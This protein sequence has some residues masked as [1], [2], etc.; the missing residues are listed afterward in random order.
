M[1]VDYTSTTKTIDTI[2]TD[3][4]KFYYGEKNISSPYKI[5][6]PLIKVQP[7]QSI[8]FSA[9]STIGCEK[10]S[11]IYSAV[12]VCFFKEINPNEYN[13]II[14]S[15]GQLSENRIIE[16]GLINIIE[17]IENISKTIP[18]EQKSNQGEII[19]HGENHTIGNLISHGMQKHKNVKFAGYNIPHLLEEKVIITYELVNDKIML[20]DIIDDVIIYYIKIF[21]ELINLNSDLKKSTKKNPKKNSK[22]NSKKL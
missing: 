17:T 1:Y 14:E 5:A 9:I 8:N 12:S 7:G 21:K 6:I 10:E 13:L 19:I 4:V 18:I 3:D 22:K 2:T 20:K 11:S 15:R 16:L